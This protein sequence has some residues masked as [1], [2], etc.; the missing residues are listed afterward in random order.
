MAMAVELKSLMLGAI[1]HSG[2]MMK[3]ISTP[4]L[5]N[6]GLL[7]P[8]KLMMNQTLVLIQVIIIMHR[9]QLM[10]LTLMEYQDNSSQ[11][12]NHSGKTEM[13]MVRRNLMLMV[14]LL[15]GALV[16]KISI[17]KLN[18]HG[19]HQLIKEIKHQVVILLV[20]L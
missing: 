10:L 2:Q 3:M 19:L 6:L 15:N 4:K 13:V 7:Q 1:K 18:S 11:V 5:L 20:S 9:L 16:K 17:R 14:I 12:K 8:M